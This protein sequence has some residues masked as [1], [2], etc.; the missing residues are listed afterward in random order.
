MALHTFKNA[1]PTTAIEDD[2]GECCTA[3][4]VTPAAWAIVEIDAAKLSAVQVAAE[5]AGWEY[6]GTGDQRPSLPTFTQSYSTASTTVAAI[7]AWS[8]P[9]ISASYPAGVTLLNGATASDLNNLAGKCANLEAEIT[10]L[11]A[12]VVA[13]K[14]NANALIDVLQA[15]RAAT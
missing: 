5:R 4:P 3:D 10:A 2:L 12:E 9:A 7:G 1:F 15:I 6:V 14:G 8:P 13:L 11:R